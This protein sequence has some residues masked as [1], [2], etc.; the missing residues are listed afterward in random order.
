MKKKTAEKLNQC[1]KPQIIYSLD[2]QYC[3]IKRIKALY[4]G[5]LFLHFLTHLK[6]TLESG[7]KLQSFISS[8]NLLTFVQLYL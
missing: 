1:F 8:R 3:Q 2:I 6:S 7:H 5:C 4:F